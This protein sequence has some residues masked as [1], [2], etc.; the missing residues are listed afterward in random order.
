M[1]LKITV[2]YL[3]VLGIDKLFVTTSNASK[4]ISPI[5]DDKVKSAFLLQETQHFLLTEESYYRERSNHDPFY[6][7]LAQT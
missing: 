6:F 1:L 4:V 2:Q 3:P 5:F 7:S